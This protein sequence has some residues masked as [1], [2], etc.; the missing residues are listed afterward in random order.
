MIEKKEN[1]VITGVSTGIGY[2]IL[3]EC[4]ARGYRVFGSVRKEEDA[5]RLKAE[6]GDAFFPLIFDVTNGDA[7]LES[8]SAVSKVVGNIGIKCLVNNS[9]IAL[10]GPLQ[11]QSA[12]DHYP[13]FLGLL[14]L[15]TQLCKNNDPAWKRA[16]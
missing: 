13:Y 12:N 7:V 14:N 11:Y 16:G 3:K 9:G 6:F 8:A 4:L 5:A 2:G 15:R 10:G 1:I